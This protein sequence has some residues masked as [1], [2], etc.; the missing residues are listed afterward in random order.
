MV[1]ITGGTGFIGSH[2]VEYFREQGVDIQPVTRDIADIRDVNALTKAFEGADCV[3]HNAAKA[4]DWGSYEDFFENNVTG[5]LNV[6][7]ACKIN[8]IKR[9]IMTGSCS[10]Y[11]EE[12]CR[13][14]KDENSLPKSHYPYFFDNLFPCAMNFYRDTKQIAKDCAV[15]VAETEKINL[16]VID[17]V[18]VYGERE[19]NTGFYEYLKTAKSIPFIMG[20]TKNKFHVIYAKDLAKAYYLV[21]QADLQGTHIFIAG[22]ADAQPMEKIYSLF[23]EIAGFKKPKNIPKWVIYPAAF[24]MEFLWTVFR[25]KKPPILTRGRVNMFYDNIEYNARKIRSELGFECEY[26]LNNGIERTVSWYKKEGL[27]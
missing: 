27:L 14:I 8:G 5:T 18:W 13:E 3:I 25:S 24:I 12:N 26:S 9:I 11:G 23:C 15:S 19:F 20:S 10:V 7:K 21:Y 17:P 2:I 1:K 16:T 4:C 22:D 6:F